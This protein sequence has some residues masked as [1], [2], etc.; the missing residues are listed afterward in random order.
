MCIYPFEAVEYAQLYHNNVIYS[1]NYMYFLLY[2]VTAFIASDITVKKHNNLFN[3]YVFV[4]AKHSPFLH[5]R[6]LRKTI[7]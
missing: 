7:F 4:D 3:I 2:L 5:K 1:H 6:C